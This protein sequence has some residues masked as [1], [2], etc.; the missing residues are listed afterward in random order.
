VDLFG[1][2]PFAD[3]PTMVLTRWDV[4]RIPVL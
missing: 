3:T 2:G 4:D 1:L